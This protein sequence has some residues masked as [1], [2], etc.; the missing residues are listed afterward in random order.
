MLVQK[1]NIPHRKAL[2]FSYFGP[3]GQG[4]GIPMGAPRPH[5][6]KKNLSSFF[7][8]VEAM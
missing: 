2:I 5:P 7:E 4:P 8:V 6:F 3:E 1:K